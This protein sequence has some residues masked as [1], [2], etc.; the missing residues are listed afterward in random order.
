M[1]TSCKYD[2]IYYRRKNQRKNYHLGI[3]NWEKNKEEQTVGSI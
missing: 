2:F 1:L 3:G